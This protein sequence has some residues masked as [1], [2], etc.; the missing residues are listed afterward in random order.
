M[1]EI[2]TIKIDGNKLMKAENKDEMMKMILKEV[3]SQATEEKESDR[4]ISKIEDAIL[5]TIR[6]I[7]EKENDEDVECDCEFCRGFYEEDDEECD[8]DN[9]DCDCEDEEISDFVKTMLFGPL[10]SRIAEEAEKEEQAKTEP[11]KG[12]VQGEPI[13]KDN[14]VNRIS[15]AAKVNADKHNYTFTEMIEEFS[16]GYVGTFSNGKDSFIYRDETLLI[17]EDFE[18]YSAPITPYIINGTYFKKQIL[19]SNHKALEL[20]LEGKVVNFKVELFGRNY[21]GTLTYKNNIPS[22]K[23]NETN[24]IIGN[25]EAIILGALMNGTWFL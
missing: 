5:N 3:E 24:D 23:I 16:K 2:K 6:K 19:I 15:A 7:R 22:Y 25:Q 21:T 13:I 20:C 1:S 18:I 9:C 8:C 4:R 10:M 14:T 11:V 12:Y 17:E